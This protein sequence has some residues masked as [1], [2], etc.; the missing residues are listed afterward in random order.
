MKQSMDILIVEP[1]HQGRIPVKAVHDILD[2]PAV[3]LQKAAL[4]D[5]RTHI[6]L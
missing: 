3:Q 2:M 4:Y 6:P 1:A 5:L